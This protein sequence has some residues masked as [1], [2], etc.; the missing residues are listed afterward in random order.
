VFSLQG[1]SKDVAQFSKGCEHLL[2]AL[3]CRKEFSETERQMISYYCHEI[4][5]KTEHLRDEQKKT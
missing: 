5:S 3:A 1:V 4:M 2:S